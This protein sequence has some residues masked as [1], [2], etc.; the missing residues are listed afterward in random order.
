[1]TLWVNRDRI[2]PAESRAM[3]VLPRITIKFGILPE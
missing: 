3:S 2:E 1:M